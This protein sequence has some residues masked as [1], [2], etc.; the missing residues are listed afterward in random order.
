[1]K[2]T[3]LA[4]AFIFGA[5]IFLNTKIEIQDDDFKELTGKV[6][7][8]EKIANFQEDIEIQKNE[9]RECC[10]FTDDEGNEKSC[11]AMAGFSCDYCSTF[12]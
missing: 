2:E 4:L 10:S 6:I 11:F 3:Y 9:L 5:L 7:S 12:C 8:E 1:M